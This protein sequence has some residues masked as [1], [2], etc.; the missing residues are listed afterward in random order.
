MTWKACRNVFGPELAHIDVIGRGVL[1]DSEE[2]QERTRAWEINC[3]ITS[4]PNLVPLV[5]SQIPQL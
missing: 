1:T 3:N 5:S 2:L 4:M